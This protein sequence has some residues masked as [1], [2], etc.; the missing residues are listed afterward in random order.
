MNIMAVAS[1]E[2]SESN[3]NKTGNEVLTLVARDI[4]AATEERS[5]SWHQQ[6]MFGGVRA[7]H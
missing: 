2:Q 6:A 5:A 7:D 3:Q 1:I 4:S